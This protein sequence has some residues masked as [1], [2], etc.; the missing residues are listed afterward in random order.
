MGKIRPKRGGKYQQRVGQ[1]KQ[2]Q[3]RPKGGKGKGKSRRG[4]SPKPAKRSRAPY[5][6]IPLPKR[7]ILIGHRDEFSV[8][9]GSERRPIWR[10]HDVVLPNLYTGW[11]DLTITSE[12]PLFIR[13]APPRGSVHEGQDVTDFFNHGDPNVPVIPGSSIRGVVRTLFEIV[14]YAKFLPDE[15][16][17][18]AQLVFRA[19]G[20]PHS[21][22]Q[23]YR[24]LM[25]KG[26]VRGGYLIKKGADYYIRPSKMINGVSLV[27]IRWKND[28]PEPSKAGA[29]VE[30]YVRR[31]VLKGGVE[32]RVKQQDFRQFRP[33]GQGAGAWVR[34]IIPRTGPM[35]TRKYCTGLFE[36]D[37]KAGD[38]ILPRE[39]VQLWK[40][41]Q[42]LKRGIETR[43]IEPGD[44]VFYL[45]DHRAVSKD[46]PGGIVFFG[47]TRMF[48]IPYDKRISDH[49]PPKLKAPAGVDMVEALFGT[50]AQSEGGQAIA[51]RLRFEDAVAIIEKGQSVFYEGHNGLRVPKVLSSPKP[52]AI[53]HYLEQ[54]PTAWAD[55]RKLKTWSDADVLIRGYKLYWHRKVTEA[56]IF[57]TDA[58]GRF[59]AT[60]PKDKERVSVVIRPVR[61]GVRF[62]GKIRFTNLNGIELGGLLTVLDLGASKRHKIGMVKP[63]GMGSVRFDVS[64]HI[65]DHSSR[66][67]RLFTEDGMIASSSSQLETGEIEKLK[68]EFGSFVLEALGESRQSLWDIPRLELLARMLEWDKAPS[69][70]STTYLVLDPQGGKNEWKNR[71]ILPRPDKV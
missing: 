39:I 36:E 7:P 22:G 2:R 30:G 34:V 69:K 4:G 53:Q 13:G 45:F 35:P 52:T 10:T 40:Q 62:R 65:V 67:S 38:L 54:P 60:P 29:Y 70:D 5:N 21:L 64:V 28:C 27:R 31:S 49:V 18:D 33:P 32:V 16:F 14:S 6:F 12:T 24:K 43:K 41:D 17:T 44:P 59:L 48:R 61:S 19:V 26:N 63:Y 55:T 51:S 56:D 58:R 25:E 8:H 50:V 57:E 42:D 3:Y 23:T 9:V 47:P 15:S 66:Y 46:N 68:K 71:P 11:I 1:N 37:P 20:D